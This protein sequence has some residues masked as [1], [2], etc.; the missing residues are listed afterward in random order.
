MKAL[1]LAAS[2]ASRN[3]APRPGLDLTAGPVRRGRPPSGPLSLATLVAAAL[4]LALTFASSTALPATTAHPRARLATAARDS[5]S[6]AA[7]PFHRESTHGWRA[8]APCIA[9]PTPRLTP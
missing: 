6:G 7:Q 2:R 3:R 9:P 1:P 8:I 5:E 4:A